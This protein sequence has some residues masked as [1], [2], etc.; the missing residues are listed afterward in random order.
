MS[1]ILW[2]I[3]PGFAGWC[4]CG[5]NACRPTCSGARTEPADEPTAETLPLEE[6]AQLLL[7]GAAA[8]LR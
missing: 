3:L 5:V 2:S 7:A 1:L 6:A 8:A 4:G